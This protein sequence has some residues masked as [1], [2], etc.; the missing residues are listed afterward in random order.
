MPRARD[1]DPGTEGGPRRAATNL[2]CAPFPHLQGDAGARDAGKQHRM[3]TVACAHR[4]KSRGAESGTGSG[5]VAS[6]FAKG[7]R[8]EPQR[9]RQHNVSEASGS[10]LLERSH[11]GLLIEKTGKKKERKRANGP[12]TSTGYVSPLPP[13]QLPD[14]V[15]VGRPT[16]ARIVINCACRCSCCSQPF[17]LCVLGV[18]ENDGMFDVFPTLFHHHS[19]AVI[20]DNSDE[21]RGTA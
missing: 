14:H 2:P 10:S 18:Q 7:A 16:E 15:F 12:Q 11:E 9:G 1:Q 17:L 13:L 4:H 19:R 8:R 5:S 6:P 20:L 3:T 21:L